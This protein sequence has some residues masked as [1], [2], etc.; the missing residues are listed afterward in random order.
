ML[1]V[2]FSI[3]FW[4]VKIVWRIVVCQ[5]FGL[6][7]VT[8]QTTIWSDE[9]SYLKKWPTTVQ[10]YFIKNLIINMCSWIICAFF[11]SNGMI[12]E[13]MVC[14]RE[15]INGLSYVTFKFYIG[16]DEMS[17]LKESQKNRPTTLQQ[18]FFKYVTTVICL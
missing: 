6:S 5:K 16:F 4:Y 15:A 10:Q 7:Y 18:I 14:I 12:S 11:N 3:V 2:I 17:Y 9:M 1:Y 13:A 8:L